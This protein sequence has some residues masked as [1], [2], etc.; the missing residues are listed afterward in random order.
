[1]KT[2]I[3][4]GTGNIGSAI[5]KQMI[6]KG[7]EVSVLCRN[8][9]SALKAERM[10]AGIIKG[11]LEKPASW[12][13]ELEKFDSVI[14][15]ACGFGNDM[16][17]IDNNFISAVI[18]SGAGRK[19]SLRFLYTGGVWLF[20]SSDKVMNE[21][22]EKNPVTEFRWMIEN[23][24]KLKNNDNISR[25]VIHPANVVREEDN[26]VPPI[27][28]EEYNDTGIPAA[29]GKKENLW[30]LVEVNNLARLYI[31]ALDSAPANSEFIGCDEP[32]IKVEELIRRIPGFDHEQDIIEKPISYW[33]QKYGNWT[34]GYSL[35][36]RFSSGRAKNKLRWKPQKFYPGRP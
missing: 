13:S 34:E 25:V 27:L 12:I 14:H 11:N 2:L 32:G 17:N 29:P 15:T 31:N 7:A 36:Q 10:N 8:E 20:G 4:G 24:D 1:M 6:V 9:K 5:V 28:I 22:S 3:T 33:I 18:N 19:K 21:A 26:Y 16:G 23:S 35:S 30:P